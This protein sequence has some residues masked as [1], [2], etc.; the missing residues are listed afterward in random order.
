MRAPSAWGVAGSPVQHSVTPMLFDVIGRA[1]GLQI[2]SRLVI[3]VDSVD[4][5]LRYLAPLEGDIWLSCTTP[6]KYGLSKRYGDQSPISKSVNQIARKD[7]HITV[8]NTDGL[9]FLEACESEGIVPMGKTLKMRGGGATA[10]SIAVEWTRRGGSIIP[11]RGR[12]QLPDGP[13][14]NTENQD[15]EAD[16]ALDLDVPPG[17]RADTDMMAKKTL[18]ISYG[19]D[20]EPGDFSI[21]MV[22]AQHLVAWRTLYAPQM[23]DELPSLEDT[24]GALSEEKWKNTHS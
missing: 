5:L 14:S 23:S 18:S 12:R 3:E 7:G 4:E 16:V 21:R 13:W 9:G 24:I 6:L 10:R 19:P 20:W 8:G 11:I 2:P 22:C 1:V 15:V 17:Q